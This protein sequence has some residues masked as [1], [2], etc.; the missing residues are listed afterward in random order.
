M[1][2]NFENFK[3]PKKKYKKISEEKP[4]GRTQRI[5]SKYRKK[6]EKKDQQK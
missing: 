4:P 3:L 2:K 5:K 6:N 1:G